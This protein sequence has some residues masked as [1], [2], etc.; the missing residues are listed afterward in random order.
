M[1]GCHAAPAPPDTAQ[2]RIGRIQVVVATAVG[3][4]LS[5]SP[6][7]SARVLHPTVLRGRPFSVAATAARASALCMLRSV[8]L[9][10]YWRSSPLVFSFVPRCQGL[11]GSQK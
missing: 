6:Q 8:P 1:A 10:K 5:S 7:A 11:W 9:G 2:R 4:D 3:A